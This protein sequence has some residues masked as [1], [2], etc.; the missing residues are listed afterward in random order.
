MRSPRASGARPRGWISPRATPSLAT[1]RLL[2]AE[3]MA[4]FADVFDRDLPYRLDTESGPITAIPFSMEV[5][6][7]P[8]CVR[9][10]HAPDAFVAMLRTLVSDWR[11][12]VGGS[13]CVDITAHAHVFGRPAGAIAFKKALDIAKQSDTVW[14]TQ[15]AELAGL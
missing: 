5:N 6:D 2:A 10:G 8:L 4:W 12:T 14:L 3:G 7:F 1:P 9:Y 13:G 15:H 11:D